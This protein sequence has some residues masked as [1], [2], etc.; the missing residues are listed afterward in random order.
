MLVDNL[1][2]PLVAAVKPAS[3]RTDFYNHYVKPS[4][5]EAGGGVVIDPAKEGRNYRVS[6]PFNYDVTCGF[7]V[8]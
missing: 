2:F 8:Q 5:G 4:R 6:V 7:V 1:V 3:S